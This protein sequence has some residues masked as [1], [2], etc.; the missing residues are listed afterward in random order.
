MRHSTHPA[1]SFSRLLF[2]FHRRQSPAPTIAMIS[3]ENGPCLDR[4]D[5]EGRGLTTRGLGDLGVAGPILHE[6][7]AGGPMAPA[8]AGAIFLLGRPMRQGGSISKRNSACICY[9]VAQSFERRKRPG[10]EGID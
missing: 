7:S 3:I 9:R 4:G 5:Q 6:L 8:I 2:E 1:R 10:E